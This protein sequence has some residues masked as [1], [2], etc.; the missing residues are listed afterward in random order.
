MK[1]F[2]SCALNC[3]F[4]LSL[5][6]FSSIASEQRDFIDLTSDHW[7]YVSVMSLVSDGTVSGFADGEFKPGNMVS[8]AEFVKMI[9][10]GAERRT[11]EF[12]DVNSSHWGY[13]YIMCSGLEGNGNMF[14]P[15]IPITRSD[16]LNLIWKRN[17]SPKGITAPSIIT[18]QNSNSDAAAWGYTYGIMVGDDGVNLRL[19]DGLS[20]AEAA[21]LIVRA[22]GGSSVVNNFIDTVSP[23]ALEIMFRSVKL[24][25]I[26]D[27]DENRTITYGEMARAAVRL[28]SEEFEP[29][30]GT[31]SVETPFEHRYAKDL[32]AVGHES[33]GSDKVSMDYIDKTATVQDT[34]TALT[35]SMIRKSRSAVR[36]GAKGNYYNDVAGTDNTMTDI[37]LT[38]CYQN[39]VQLYAD[40]TIKPDKA[41]TLKE[42]ACIMLQLD[43]L[44]GAHSEISSDSNKNSKI[45][46]SIKTYPPNYS[47]FQC[48]L[49]DLPNEIYTTAFSDN[50][51]NSLPIMSYD[52]AREYSF[53]FTNMLQEI[54]NYC[55]SGKEV[56]I[57]FTYYPSLV[58]DNGN[59]ATLRVKCEITENPKNIS[60]NEIFKGKI[61]IDN[62]VGAE[63]GSVFFADIVTGKPLTDIYMSADSA[64]L[65]QI[66]YVQGADL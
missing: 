45:R 2:I 13:E 30:Y 1:K 65:K 57:R 31:Y 17:G 10:F 9:G 7:A 26:N 25:D 36:Y 60:L 50:Y 47:D 34:L 23:D 56:K 11:S 52:F 3:T 59:G 29:S 43:Y 14:N 46:K 48:I 33:I 58:C 24:F 63:K 51:N 15:D 41:I 38:Y 35:Y 16:V 22:R 12:H 19:N 54:K 55:E 40:G 32:Y 5:L 20:R 27:Y 37:C 8:R 21:V 61:E 53:I 64:L 39:G 18:S 44:I 66:I 4:I 62:T 6:Q 42:F 49:E 28:G